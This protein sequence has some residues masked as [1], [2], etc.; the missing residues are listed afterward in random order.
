MVH[1][2][3]DFGQ[4]FHVFSIARILEAWKRFPDSGK[5]VFCI[6]AKMEKCCVSCL[7]IIFLG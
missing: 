7:K 3:P 5:W 1:K 6:E 2:K 4:F